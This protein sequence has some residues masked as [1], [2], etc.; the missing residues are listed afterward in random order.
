[1]VLSIGSVLTAL[2]LAALGL[3]LSVLPLAIASLSLAGVGFGA[4][5]GAPTRYIITNETPSRMRGTAVGLLS[6]FLIVGQILGGS[7]AGGFDGGSFSDILSNLFGGSVGGAYRLAFEAFAALAV[8]TAFGTL[9]L[10]P[11]S[12]ERKEAES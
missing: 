7:F 11:R 3:T 8:V 12:K 1:M 9:F 6:I 5:L 10:L 2:G 4:L